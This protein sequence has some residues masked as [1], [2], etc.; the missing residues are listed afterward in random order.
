MDCMAGSSNFATESRKIKIPDRLLKNHVYIAGSR[1]I[2][3]NEIIR[4]TFSISYLRVY[5]DAF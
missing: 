2:N 1:E 5:F 4:N 3:L